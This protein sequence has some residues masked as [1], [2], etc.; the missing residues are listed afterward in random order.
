MIK[1]QL[2]WFFRIFHKEFRS[3]NKAAFETVM[4]LSVSHFFGYYNPKQLADYLGIRHQQL[5]EHL[6]QL[7]IYSVKKM[8]T[9]LMVQIASPQIQE[10]LSKSDATKSRAGISLSADNSVIDRFGRMIRC[11]YSWYSGR[12]KKVVNGNDLL[13]IVLTINGMAIPLSLLFCSKQGRANTNKPSLLLSMLANLKQE[14]DLHGIDIT[15]FPLTL[16]SWFVS[17]P[18]RQ[19]LY[20]LGFKNII[21]AGKGNYSFEIGSKKQKVR[22]WK[23]QIQLKTQQWGIDVPSCR[24]KANSPTFGDVVLFFFQ[25]STTRSYYLMDFSEKAHRAAEIWHIWKQHHLIEYFWRMLK[26]VFKIN[27]M[28]LRGDGLYSALLVKVVAYLLA[29]RLKLFVFS[30]LT[31]VQIMR[32][33]RRDF[34]LDDFF[35]EHFHSY[36]SV[37]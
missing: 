8:L 36:N 31:I 21:I 33:I 32:K 23:K 4:L 35:N 20:Q 5:Y 14:F 28:Q 25:K 6:S 7:S 17:Q 9:K 18:L 13:G 27:S 10:V 29:L 34:D 37:T 19:Q 11:T 16:D 1:E 2:N 12:W 24:V 26:S 15:Q 3:N 30:N 22:E